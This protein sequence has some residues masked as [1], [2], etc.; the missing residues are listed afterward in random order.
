MLCGV[1]L[2]PSIQYLKFQ[3]CGL[4]FSSRARVEK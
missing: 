2:G 1:T 4:T 3:F